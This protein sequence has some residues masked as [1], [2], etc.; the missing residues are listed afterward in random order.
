[1]CMRRCRSH[2]TYV[3]TSTNAV[4]R[5]PEKNYA[6]VRIKLMRAVPKRSGY[7]MM[8]QCYIENN[9]HLRSY[10]CSLTIQYVR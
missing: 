1:M 2:N 7:S 4:D 8:Q 5:E 10:A 9:E 3:A 6:Q